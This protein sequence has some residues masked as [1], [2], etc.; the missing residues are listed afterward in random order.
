MAQT[1][2]RYNGVHVYGTGEGME[3]DEFDEGNFEL[4]F[5]LKEMKTFALQ[6]RQKTG[7]D[8]HDKEA[9]DSSRPA[10]TKTW[11]WLNFW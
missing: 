6:M 3:G 5:L 8:L 11:K 1:L 9:S 4:A 2:Q 7:L 10:L